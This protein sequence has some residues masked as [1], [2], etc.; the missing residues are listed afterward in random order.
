MPGSLLDNI[1]QEAPKSDSLL[2]KIYSGTPSKGSDISEAYNPPKTNYDKFGDY[3]QFVTPE[4]DQ[5]SIRSSYQGTTAE[6]AN[7]LG[8]AALNVVPSIIGNIASIADLED[9]YNQDKEVGNAVTQYME[10]IKAATKEALPIYGENQLES[11]DMGQS[12]WWTSNFSS[13]AESAASFAATGA[14]LGMGVKGLGFLGKIAGASSTVQK[15]IQGVGGVSSLVALN[16]AEAIPA[17]VDVYNKSLDYQMN[18]LGKTEEGARQVAA[19]AAAYSINLGRLTI[20]LNI[21][22]TLAFLRTS[23][24]TRQAIKQA[25]LRSAGMKIAEEGLQETGEELIQHVAESEGNRYGKVGKE[26]NY[27]INNTVSDVFSAEG[28]EAGILGAL[29]GMA[30]TGLSEGLDIATGKSEEQNRLYEKQQASLKQLEQFSGSP[31]LK[32]VVSNITKQASII[33][34]LNDAQAEG[35]ETKVESLKNQLLINQA[36]NSFDAG[37]TDQLEEMYS[38]I[39]KTPVEEGESKYGKG[40]KENAIKATSQIRQ[41]EN[42]WN[43]F[44]QT[45]PDTFN[46]KELFINKLQQKDISNRIND[47]KQSE[48]KLASEIETIKLNSEGGAAIPQEVELKAIQDNISKLQ[49]QLSYVQQ[50]SVE[51]VNPIQEQPKVKTPEQKVEEFK[52]EPVDTSENTKE[53]VSVSEPL[54]T[55]TPKEESYKEI[56]YNHFIDTGEVSDDTVKRIADKIKGGETLSSCWA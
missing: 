27:N 47:L 8:R 17:A 43:K 48:S 29:G 40:F 56:E 51:L 33:N 45:V 53:P 2:D 52:N 30:Q 46:K 11:L 21:T 37:T 25:G 24:M 42:D 4:A 10:E 19:D 28:L 38:A 55:I 3:D 14:G 1:F 44:M 18:T 12:E 5:E 15:A 39:S 7:G 26:Y 54:E 16:Q 36:V 50:K 34:D 9:Y 35:D 41:W 23:A 49:K 6:V 22:S 20:P 31:S 13:L 32:D